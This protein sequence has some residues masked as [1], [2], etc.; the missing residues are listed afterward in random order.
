[1]AKVLKVLN[2]SGVGKS[3]IF[4]VIPDNRGERPEREALENAPPSRTPESS[5]SRWLA[6]A[7]VI[8]I[9]GLSS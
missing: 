4:T 7:R 6:P 5:A 2:F 8:D 1:M 3:S 9:L